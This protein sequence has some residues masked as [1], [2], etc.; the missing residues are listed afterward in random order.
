MANDRAPRG[1]SR[2]ILSL[3]VMLLGILL[4]LLVPT[5]LLVRAITQ[6]KDILPG[7]LVILS[8]TGGMALIIIAAALRD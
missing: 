4:L 2:R 1:S 8:V 5:I 3:A 7:T 6:S